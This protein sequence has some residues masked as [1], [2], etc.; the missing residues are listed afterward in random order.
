MSSLTK[1]FRRGYRAV[2]DIELIQILNSEIKHE[3]STD[4][5]KGHKVGSLGNFELSWDGKRSKDVVLRRKCH[6]GEEIAL[7]AMLGPCDY[8]RENSLPFHALMKICIKKPEL[9]SLLQF[10]CVIEN[11]DYGLS[12]FTISHVCYLPSS[13]CL[14]DSVYKGPLFSDL[15]PQLQAMYKEYLIDKGIGEDLTSFLILHLHKK[16]KDQYVNWLARLEATLSKSNH[17]S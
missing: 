1:I 6:S 11:K 14:G 3:Q 15:D 10:D 17:P 12:D 16:E 4:Q 9:E 5:F 8:V 7:S 13:S 2:R